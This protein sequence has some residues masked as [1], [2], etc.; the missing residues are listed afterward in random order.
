M[1]FK[2]L[3]AGLLA[4]AFAVTGAQQARAG[5]DVTDDFVCYKGKADKNYNGGTGYS[6]NAAGV[7][8]Q[9]AA[10]QTLELK[11]PFLFCVPQTPALNTDHLVCYKA[12][13]A[14]LATPITVVGTNALGSV[15]I[16][17]KKPFLYCTSVQKTI[18]LGS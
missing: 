3:A 7:A 10:A 8:S 11:K 1:K 9:F 13:G 14:N 6:G 2:V 18:F 5:T 15:K 4:A 16:E 12:K 17:N